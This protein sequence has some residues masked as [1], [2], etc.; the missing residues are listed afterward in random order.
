MKTSIVTGS[1]GLLGQAFFRSTYF[2]QMGLMPLGLTRKEVSQSDLVSCQYRPDDIDLLLRGR[3]VSEVVHCAGVPSIFGSL[4]DPWLD[5]QN[6]VDPFLF[7][8]ELAKRAGA[9]LIL[10]SSM[11]VYGETGERAEES[12]LEPSS[13]YGL[14]KKFCEEFLHLY[15]RTFGVEF[16]I[17]RPAVFFSHEGL[18]KNVLFDLLSGFRARQNPIRLFCGLKTTLE[19][20]HVDDIISALSFLTTQ[21]IKNQTFNIGCGEVWSVE[22]LFNWF[23]DHFGYRPEVE[24]IESGVQFRQLSNKK[25]AE[26][27]WRPKKS[28]AD[29]LELMVGQ[30]Q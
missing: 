29:Y 24:L 14:S 17:L 9:R 6:N 30:K 1:S 27:G 10:I 7:S 21:Q 23:C 25:L 13:F 18:K 16:L 28:M 26:T 8:C 15:H 22:Q 20:I 4:R 5:H 2:S 3:V 12:L 19:F 11:E